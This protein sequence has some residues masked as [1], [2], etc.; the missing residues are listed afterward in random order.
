M[1]GACSTNGGKGNAHRHISWHNG[2]KKIK[3]S[4]NLTN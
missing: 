3:L 1:G 2:G 4:L